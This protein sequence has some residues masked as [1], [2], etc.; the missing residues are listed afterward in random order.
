MPA[1]GRHGIW[2]KLPREFHPRDFVGIAVNRYAPVGFDLELRQRPFHTDLT[3]GGIDAPNVGRYAASEWDQV[4]ISA[5]LNNAEF[6]Q[7]GKHIL[8]RGIVRFRDL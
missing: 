3:F 7:R 5:R 8:C 1:Q 4:R 2:H 6:A